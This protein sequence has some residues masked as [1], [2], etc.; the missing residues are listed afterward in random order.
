MGHPM[1]LRNCWVLVYSLLVLYLRQINWWVFKGI[2]VI[3]VSLAF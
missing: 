2:D 3:Q 1:G